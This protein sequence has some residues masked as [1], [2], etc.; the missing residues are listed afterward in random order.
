MAIATTMGTLNIA[1]LIS[2]L[3]HHSSMEPELNRLRM[4]LLPADL[5]SKCPFF[6]LTSRSVPI[7]LIAFKKKKEKKFEK[8]RVHYVLIV[9]RKVESIEK[10]L[11]EI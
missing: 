4:L 11:I 3:S 7:T 1:R 5:I 10:E 2:L 6:P 9:L 8:K